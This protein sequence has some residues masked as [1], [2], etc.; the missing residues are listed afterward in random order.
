MSKKVSVIVL[1]AGSRG[2]RYAQYANLAPDKMEIVGVAEPI[3]AR[4]EFMRTTYNIPAENCV[5][6]W[7]ELLFRPKMADAVIIAMQDQ[8]HYEPAM[9]AIA[10]GYHILL[11]KPMAPTPAQC[12]AIGKA[13]EEKGVHVIVCHVLRYTPFFGALKR[14][15]DEDR[16]GKVMNIIHTEGVGN[17]HQ[18]HS[19]VRGNWHVEANST[20]M[21]LAKSCHDID[22]L[23]WLV[24]KSF[25]RIQSFGTLSHFCAKNRPEGAPT[26]CIEGCPHGETCYYNAVKLYL[27]DKKN[28]WFRGA[29]T[30][31]PGNPSDELV[32]KAL[33][34]SDYG[35]C[36]YALDND[37]VDHQTVNMEFEDDVYAVFTM[38]A[39]N[40]GGR[41]VRIM[42]TKG[43]LS[44]QM[45]KSDISIYNFATKAYETV[46]LTDLV[47]DESIIGGHGGGDGGIISSFCEL[48]SEGTVTT[49]VCSAMTSARNHVAVFAAEQSRR[50]GTVVDVTVYE[51]GL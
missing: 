13:A 35:K 1:G 17:I 26:R 42:G 9:K 39:F 6:D 30:G 14:L 25:K 23:Q 44:A 41:S 48:L 12:L 24:G 51:Q 21:L 47:A 43:E 33:R 10:L 45:G 4:R 46:A 18:S 11:E 27:D 16:I 37:V 29:A 5:T 31:M 28:A 22:I 19:Y 36:V 7:T 49:S 3:E 2:S 20:P 50:A 34:E 32:E 8:M 38:S 15:I 40:K